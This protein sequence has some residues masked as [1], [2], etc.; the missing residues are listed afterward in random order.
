M[1]D[2]SS[3]WTNG[4]PTGIS[5]VH[6]VAASPRH[7]FRMRIKKQIKF[8]RDSRHATGG[9]RDGDP[10]RNR[11]ITQSGASSKGECSARFD[12]A[13]TLFVCG[14]GDGNRTRTVSLGNL[15]PPVARAP[16]TFSHVVPIDLC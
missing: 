12:C 9:K 3:L 11:E 1:L 7:E 8:C 14:A 5:F 15:P 13:A 16:G 4:S 10:V 2:L 6:K